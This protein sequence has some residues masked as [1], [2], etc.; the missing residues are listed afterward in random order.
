MLLNFYKSKF[1]ICLALLLLLCISGILLYSKSFRNIF[2]LNSLNTSID[3]PYIA[4]I[5][6]DRANISVVNA[7][8]NV[9]QHVPNDWKVQMVIPNKY[10]PYYMN[11]SLA[12]YIK[13][14]RILFTSL[15][16]SSNGRSSRNYIN[17]ILT[18]IEFWRQVKG[19]RVLFFQ[20]DSVLCS[21]ASSNITDFLEYDFIGAPW[22]VGGCCNGGLS[23]RNRNKIIELL[24]RKRFI[25]KPNQINEDGWFTKHLPSVNGRVAPRSVARRFSV[26][27][28]YYPSPFAIHKLRTNAFGEE[29]L[30]KLCKQCPE[31]SLLRSDCRL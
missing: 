19:K 31:L 1:K 8:L 9:F 28:I 10:W 30:R 14:N 23:I 13:S 5:V 17:P 7:V 2:Y 25:W 24:E 16:D 15:N 11:S 18:S 29:N 26:E 20:S 21:N 12:F 6:D 4:L 3:Y 27:T 22:R